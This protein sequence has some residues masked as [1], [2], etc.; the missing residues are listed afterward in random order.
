MPNKQ[1]VVKA[2]QQ[3]SG[4]SRTIDPRQ[5][6]QLLVTDFGDKLALSESQAS[7]A[8][9]RIANTFIAN[10]EGEVLI[11]QIASFWA[12]QIGA[13]KKPPTPLAMASFLSCRSARL[14]ALRS[15]YDSSDSIDS[16]TSDNRRDHA[17]AAPL[18]MEALRGR[19]RPLTLLLAASL[20]LLLSASTAL[21][22]CPALARSHR[23]DFSRASYAPKMAVPW[24]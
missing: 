18:A 9:A 4:G 14:S 1:E 5:L 2:L 23:P 17:V 13:K 16:F 11:D 7:L 15:E 12:T 22:V 3:F 20:L 21:H 6:K 10:A 8:V 19:R 24:S